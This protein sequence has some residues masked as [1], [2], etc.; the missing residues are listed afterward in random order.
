[1]G[2]GKDTLTITCALSGAFPICSVH[3]IG[4]NS[5][6]EVAIF[7]GSVTKIRDTSCVKVQSWCKSYMHEGSIN[8]DVQERTPQ[9]QSL[10][11]IRHNTVTIA[12]HTP[13][14]FSSQSLA[15]D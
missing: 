1:M 4:Y 8:L 11:Q 9:A 13:K 15:T 14:Y 3:K 6:G 5:V 10:A 12:G 2:L 7:N